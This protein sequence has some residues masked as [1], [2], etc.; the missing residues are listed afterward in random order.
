MWLHKLLQFFCEW[1]SQAKDKY[2]KIK[3]WPMRENSVPEDNYVRNQRLVDKDTILLPPLHIKLG[4]I[5]NFVK[6]MNKHRKDF[7]YLREKCPKFSVVKLKEGIFIGSL[8][9]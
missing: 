1:G 2:G 9:S 6:A 7:E 3:D 5:K 8:N 4:L